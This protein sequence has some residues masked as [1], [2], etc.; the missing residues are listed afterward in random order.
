MHTGALPTSAPALPGWQIQK[1]TEVTAQPKRRTGLLIRLIVSQLLAIGSLL[2]WVV[3]AGPSMIAFDQGN[4]SEAWAFVLTVWAYPL[5]PLIMAI[6]AG[7]AVAF[8]K[9]RL[10]AVLA[11]LTCVPPL[12]LCLS[13]VIGPQSGLYT[14]P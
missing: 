9:N 6:S 4:I 13:T 14:L 8:R 11:G 1:M 10:S 3:A 7:G 2:F 5:F 12:L